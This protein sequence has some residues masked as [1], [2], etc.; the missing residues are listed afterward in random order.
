MQKIAPIRP[1]KLKDIRLAVIEEGP[2]PKHSRGSLILLHGWPEIAFSW[3]HQV[4]A[5]ADSG[6][7]VLAP[8]LRGFGS[9]DRPSGCE[10][11]RMPALVGDV[12]GLMDAFGLEKATVVGHDWGAIIAWAMPFYA[13]ERLAAVAGLNVPFR[14]RG[15]TPILTA[16]EAAYGPQ[17][18][19][20]QF[21]QEGRCEPI[22]EADMERTMR[23]FFRRPRVGSGVGGGAFSTPDLD[24]V[25]WLQQPP[26]TWP[27]EPFLSEEDLAVY[28]HAFARSGMTAPLHYYRNLDWNWRDMARF[29]PEGELPRIRHP[30][31]MITAELDGVLPPRL[32][33][34]IEVFFE[35]YQRIDIMGAGHWV[36]QE[37]PDEVNR[38]LLDWLAEEVA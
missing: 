6:Y 26:E 19:I 16:L 29:Q 14:P 2:P 15:G 4:R 7:H 10:N 36:Q 31:L 22:L 8:D 25:S 12:T 37:K 13:P 5:L 33:D 30:A 24:L 28:V 23:F 35:R 32:A 11:Y 17:M 34:G 1:V 27:G 9:S 21:Q 38:A 3:R 20:L 18:Y